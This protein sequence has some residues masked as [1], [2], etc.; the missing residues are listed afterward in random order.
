MDVDGKLGEEVDQLALDEEPSVSMR[1][2]SSDRKPDMDEDKTRDRV[3][4]LPRLHVSKSPSQPPETNGNMLHG[5]VQ[6]L[7]VSHLRGQYATSHDDCRHH[8]S[9]LTVAQPNSKP[10]PGHQSPLDL[11]ASAAANKFNN[12]ADT[13]K[14]R[15]TH[16]PQPTWTTRP[17]LSAPARVPQD[18]SD[19]DSHLSST[20]TTTAHMRA[21]LFGEEEE[22]EEEEEDEAPEYEAQSEDD[23]PL[24]RKRGAPLRR[25]VSGAQKGAIAQQYTF[26]ESGTAPGPHRRKPQNKRHSRGGRIVCEF[27]SGNGVPKCGQRFT[28]QADM[29]RHREN[30]HG[31]HDGKYRCP[32]CAKSLS[33]ADAVKRH[34]LHSDDANHIE[35]QKRYSKEIDGGGD[36]WQ[37]LA[38][39][40]RKSISKV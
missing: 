30:I 1:H 20:S 17:S 6:F 27:S 33:R 25:R 10:Q 3:P 38:P 4:E 11:L 29:V 9:S 2:P 39:L 40:W 35:F 22:E 36:W 26:I 13:Q 15:A 24:S 16:S 19:H 31:A 12:L 14:A 8:A 28:R 18:H 32:V 21:S 7:H 23:Q 37:A 5:P 34:V